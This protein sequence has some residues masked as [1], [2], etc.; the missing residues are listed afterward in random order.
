MDRRLRPVSHLALPRLNALDKILGRS[1]PVVCRRICDGNG[2]AAPKSWPGKPPSQS[3]SRK[4]SSSVR[5]KV[6][7]R[8]SPFAH[9]APFSRRLTSADSFTEAVPPLNL[10]SSPRHDRFNTARAPFFPVVAIALQLGVL[11]LHMALAP[12]LVRILRAALGNH[13]SAVCAVPLGTRTLSPPRSVVAIRGRG[14]SGDASSSVPD[15]SIVHKLSTVQDH[16]ITRPSSSGYRSSPGDR[17]GGDGRASTSREVP[18][19]RVLPETRQASHVRER[20]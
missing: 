10:Q 11:S 19:I 13:R 20:G 15:A 5:S 17:G 9:P 14:K 4:Y 16:F 1:Q 12:P 3:L 2:C 6:G 7:Q 18:C 8:H